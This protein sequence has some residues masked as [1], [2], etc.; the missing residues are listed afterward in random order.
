M[1]GA[2]VTWMIGAKSLTGSYGV[3]QHARTHRVGARRHQH[4][5]VAVGRR[6]RHEVGPDHAG[7]AGFVLDDDRLAELC[8]QPVADQPR[9]DVGDAAGRPGND[10]TDGAVRKVVG[11]R[12]ASGQGQRY[13]A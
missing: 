7:R 6:L 10:D 9:H 5:R 3:V 12:Q 8:V 2:V 4:Q 13:S 1:A 11:A